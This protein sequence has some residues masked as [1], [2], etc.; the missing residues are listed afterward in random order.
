MY[1]SLAELYRIAVML[2][3]TDTYG[4]IPYSKVGVANAIKSPYDSQKEVYTKMFQDL[5]KVIEVLDKYAAQNF[6]SGADKI[7]E[8]NTAAW[9]KFANS[10]K[11]RMAMRTC[12]VS[13]FN[14]DGKSSQQ[15]AEEAVAGGVMTT[16]ADG[17]YR[18]VAD[19]NPWQRFMV[20]WS[21][22]RIAAD[23]TCYMNAFNDPVVK[24]TM[25]RILLLLFLMIIIQAIRILM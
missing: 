7:Y 2:R 15:L 14:V 10:L 8:G 22:A 4:P 21:D 23:L 5:D 20:M 13:G 16:A 9:V 24:P 1:L 19:H 3:V 11:L 18:K 12:Y 17:A 6:S 25:V